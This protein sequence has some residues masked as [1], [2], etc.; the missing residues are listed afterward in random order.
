[1]TMKKRSPTAERHADLIR[2]EPLK[3]APGGL[4]LPILAA[5]CGL[6]RWQFR[7]ALAVLREVCAEKGWPPVIWTRETGYHFC[8]SDSELEEWEH[9]WVSERLTQFRRMLTS[10]LGPHLKLFPTS[11]WAEYLTAQVRA[12]ETN[13]EIA[14]RPYSP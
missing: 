6:S 1:M 2:T 8:A 13:L 9:D 12:I 5:A 10:V 4:T 14:S 3:V 11:S 7:R